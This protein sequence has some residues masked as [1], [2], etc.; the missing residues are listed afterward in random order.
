MWGFGSG[1]GFIALSVVVGG[2]GEKLNLVL[3]DLFPSSADDPKERSP[4]CSWSVSSEILNC[5]SEKSV[6]I[7]TRVIGALFLL[8]SYSV[9]ILQLLL[10]FV[11]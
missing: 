9:V 8:Y 6:W 4:A 11:I 3:S 5:A 7:P 10:L 1:L 2:Q